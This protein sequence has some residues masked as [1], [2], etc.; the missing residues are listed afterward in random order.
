[1]STVKARGQYKVP[2]AIHRRIAAALFPKLMVQT[3]TVAFIYYL[4]V[5]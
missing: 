5:R 2:K 3:E 1:M 4:L